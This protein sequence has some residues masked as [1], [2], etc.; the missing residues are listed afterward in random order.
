L[1]AIAEV[2]TFPAKTSSKPFDD[3]TKVPLVLPA[4]LRHGAAPA[5]SAAFEDDPLAPSPAR[6]RTYGRG[7]GTERAG[8]PP[9]AGASANRLSRPEGSVPEH[10]EAATMA[11][12]VPSIVGVSGSGSGSLASSRVDTRLESS[13]TSLKAPK[14][15]RKLLKRRAAVLRTRAVRRGSRP[16]RV[17][18]LHRSVRHPP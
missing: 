7:V 15:F 4:A 10:L 17:R 6:R 3:P 8:D 13:S 16:A 18:G 1:K 2:S 5:L 11:R 9:L 14:A 12:T